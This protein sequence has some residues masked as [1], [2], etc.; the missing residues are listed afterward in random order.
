MTDSW[1]LQSSL[2][3]KIW[4]AVSSDPHNK[5]RVSVFI[6]FPHFQDVETEALGD[7]MLAQGQTEG[8]PNLGC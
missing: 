4:H 8:K 5:I 7:Q 1:R 6:L 2:S 3:F